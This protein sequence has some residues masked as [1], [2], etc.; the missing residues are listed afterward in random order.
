MSGDG[1]IVP[2]HEMLLQRG[3]RSIIDEA[4]HA[5]TNTDLQDA[6]DVYKRQLMR[7]AIYI[8]FLCI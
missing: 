6:Q 1:H 3:F 4:K 7:M 2:D 5:L 8:S